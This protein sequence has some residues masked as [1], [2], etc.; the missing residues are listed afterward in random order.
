MSIIRATILVCLTSVAATGQERIQGKL[1]LSLPPAQNMLLLVAS[2]PDCPL[3]IEESKLLVD[4][5]NASEK[6]RFEYKVRS[7][8]NKPIRS[9]KIAAWWHNQTGGTLGGKP[10]DKLIQ[11]GEV[12]QNYDKDY[13]VVPLSDDL[14]ERLGPR[15]RGL[16][17]L[18]VYQVSFQDGTEYNGEPLAHSMLQFFEDYFQ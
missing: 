16:V 18:M 1:Q 6:P 2:Q 11:R 13:Q 3:L 7:T 8:S 10:L 12:I 4:L 17:V 9:Y 15:M 5:S 14:K